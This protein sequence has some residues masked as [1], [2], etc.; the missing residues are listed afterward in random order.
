MDLSTLLALVPPAYGIYAAALIIACKIATVFWQP[1]A[2]TSKWTPVYR[3]V[4]AIA[5]NV[6]WAANLI[7]PGK[8]GVPVPADQRAAAKAAVTSAGIPI[9]PAGKI[10]A[11]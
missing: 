4:S 1:P 10:K 9:V 5:L 7:Q 2:L 8:T 6:G 11:P 3:I